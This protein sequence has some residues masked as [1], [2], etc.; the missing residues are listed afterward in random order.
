[1]RIRA[2]EETRFAAPRNRL[3]R[4]VLCGI[5]LLAGHAAV[6]DGADDVLA[7]L[8]RMDA[9]WSE[10]AD[11]SKLVE[12]TERLVDG[13]VTEQM[14]LVKFRRPGQFYMKVLDGLNKNGELIYPAGAGS[15]MA[16]AHAGGFKGGFARFLQKTV[17]LR[18]VVPTEFRLDDPKI[19]E[20]QH[21]TAPDTSFGAT[22]ERIAANVRKGIDQG[23][24]QFGV[25]ETCADGGACEFRLDFSFPADAGQWHEVR[26]GETLWTIGAAYGQPMY[27]IWYANPRIRGPHKVK[28]GQALFIPRYYS[29]RGSVWVS[30]ETLLPTRIE[31][32]DAE[33]RLWERYLYSEVQTNVGLTDL[34]FDPANPDYRF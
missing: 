28:Q 16:V 34:D 8:G 15:D 21:Q 7:L 32:F 30:P 27:V 17:I 22:I 5:A 20:W 14:I 26:D 13:K 12:K 9:A 25:E 24:G 18:G 31:I 23:E 3:G 11:Y 29:A 2:T 10:I 4:I 1:M 6:A 33:D 19:G